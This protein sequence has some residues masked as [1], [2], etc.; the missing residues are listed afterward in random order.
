MVMMYH[1]VDDDIDTL[2]CGAVRVHQCMIYSVRVR[3]DRWKERVSVVHCVRSLHS[4]SCG[5][6]T[7]Y[8]ISRFRSHSKAV[9]K[10]WYD[11]GAHS[12]VA[13]S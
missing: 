11:T 12:S 4:S 2:A 1:N 13:L 10:L 8:P 6:A 5:S 7:A 9:E 3:T